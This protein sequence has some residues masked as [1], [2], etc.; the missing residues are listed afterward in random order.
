MN[1]R[2]IAMLLMLC[3]VLCIFTACGSKEETTITVD[4]A[5]Q[6]VLTDLG[7]DAVNATAPH[8]HDG[9]YDNQECYNIFFNVGDESLTYV[10]STTGEILYKGEGEHSH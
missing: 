9:T 2:I 4:D 3:M 1:K 7:D 5:W 6:I 10:V 8:V